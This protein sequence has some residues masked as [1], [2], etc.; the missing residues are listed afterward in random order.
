MTG[1]A[2]DRPGPGD[3]S[4][5]RSTPGSPPAAVPGSGTPPVSGETP[6]PESRRVVDEV[7]VGVAAAD[8]AR[9]TPGVVR[10]Q[11]GL[12]GLVVQLT[13]EIWR[14]VTGQELPDYGGVDVDLGDPAGPAVEITVVTDSRF[15]ATLVAEEIQRAATSAI[16]ARTGH[17]GATITVHVCDIAIIEPALR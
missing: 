6:D 3:A 14:K 9:S 12:I 2:A 7:H 5:A 1:P 13:A 10:L 15:Q 11:P 4:A 8:A 17:E 16:T